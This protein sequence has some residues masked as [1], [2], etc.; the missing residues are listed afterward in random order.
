MKLL[1]TGLSHKLGGIEKIIFDYISHIDLSGLEI[2]ILC[3]YETVCFENDFSALGCKIERICSRKNP[4]AYYREILK[5]ITEGRYEV[6]HLN[7]LSCANILPMLAAKRC[8]TKLIVH[9]HNSDVPN[10]CNL[11][12]L[13]KR[14]LHKINRQYVLNA[15]D[16]RL[17]CSMEA[18]FFMFGKKESFVVLKNAIDCEK[19]LFEEQ[20]RMDMRNVLK[21]SDDEILVGFVGRFEYQKNPEFLIEIFMSLVKVFPQEKFR[22]LLIGEG[23]L[24]DSIKL[25]CRNFG[26]ND[27][28]IFYG[29]T[30]DPS[31]LYCAMDCFVLPSRFEGLCL[32]GVEAQ[33]SSL[34]VLI[35]DAVSKDLV[36]T[37]LVEYLP[38]NNESL[39]AKKIYDS[40]KKNHR[41]NMF[42]EITEAGY[43]INY[44]CEKLK[45]IYMYL[46]KS[47]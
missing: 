28:V 45:R 37:P 11:T 5:V 6:V 32:V 10:G 17:A 25:K 41:K 2:G 8:G 29:K 4:F 44:E 30:N 46:G 19:F 3:E 14:I 22:L 26:L 13:L 20:K 12:M 38:L 24:E 7:I 43:N 18:G 47:K 34:P 39:W 1:I 9:S 40:V 35:S 21:I 33:C 31:P 27:K 36:I 15:S 42:V 23:S 16:I